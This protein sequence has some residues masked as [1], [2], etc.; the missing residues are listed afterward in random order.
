MTKT[1]SYRR[2]IVYLILFAIFLLLVVSSSFSYVGSI[3]SDRLYGNQNPLS[4]I[5]IIEIDD[6]SINNIGR[7][8]WQRDTFANLLTNIS[9]AKAIGIDVS[10]F[11]ASYNDD[12]LNSTLSSMDNV[13][14]ASEINNKMFFKPIF[15]VD[16]G[17]VNL[18]TDSD[19]VT[20]SLQSGLANDLDDDSMPFAFE[21]Y[22]KYSQG[23]ASLPDQKYLINFVGEPGTFES[24]SFY[25]AL[26]KDIDTKNKI[27]LIGATAP[28]LHDNY[29]VPTSRGIPMSGVEIHANIVQNT[30]LDNFLI[31]QG[32]LSL[33]ILVFLFSILGF[34]LLSRIKIYYT[35]LLVLLIIFLY[36]IIGIYLF[37]SHN[38]LLNL[39]YVP[40]V[41][42]VF[43]SVGIAINYLEEKKQSAYLTDAFGKYVS[44]NL[45]SQILDK[46]HQLKLGG[47]K[48]EITIFFSDIR[49]FTTISEKF[50]PEKLV[51]FVN[52]YLTEMTKIIMENKGTVD[53]FVGDAIMAFWNAPFLEKDHPRLA[54]L[55]AISQVRRLKEL[56]KQWKKRNLPSMNI[57]CGI[58]TGEAVIG[59]MGSEDRFDYTAMGDAV[60]LSSRL[61]GLTKQY[62]VDIIISEATYKKVKDE[63]NCRLLDVVKVKGKKLPIKIYE[64]LIENNEKKLKL[65]KQF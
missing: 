58:H 3:F 15:D 57:G 7:W 47:A 31:E 65:K 42:F 38:Y 8:P 51:H 12:L 64:L 63:F 34:F 9:D 62:G 2:L 21:L 1:I 36:G 54:C 4:N 20:R 10:F 52:E 61:E 50:S 24:V 55:A 22:N 5:M 43:T 28:N 48:R 25:D 45:L 39:F 18:L 56:Q 49:G 35:L 33:I 27:V 32:K 17:Y 37:N 60:N 26:N 11:E 53:K 16:D 30:V 13:V 14:L 44:K 59:N 40:L 23:R 41:L 19:G 29:F 6:V 46:K